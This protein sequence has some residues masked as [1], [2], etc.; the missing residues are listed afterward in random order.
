MSDRVQEPASELD[1]TPWG[2]R[3]GFR[4]TEFVVHED[5]SVELTGHRYLLSGYRMYQLIPYIEEVL[6]IRLDPRDVNQEIENKYVAPPVRNEAFIEAAE[7]AF[8]PGQIS[9]EDH[10]RLL[11]SHGQT[12]TDE[13]YRVLYGRL[14]RYADLVV[15]P[16]SEEDARQLVELAVR[17]D[18]CLV[19]YGGG[20]SVSSALALPPT[21]TRMIVSVDMHRMNRIE[22]ID[23]ENMRAC[24]QAGIVG[25]DLEEQLRRQDLTS[26]HEPDSIELSTLGGWIATNASGMKKNRYGNIERLV[27][28]VTLVSPSGVVEHLDSL[29]RVSM[30]MQ[31]QLLAFG[32]EGNLGL[33]TKAVI[34]IF[35]RPEETRYGSLVFPNFKLGVEFL[36]ELSETDYIPASIRLV[37]NIQFKF[38]MALKGQS[39]GIAVLKEKLA[40][41]YVTRIRGFDPDEMVAATIVMEGSRAEVEYQRSNL[42]RLAARYHGVP[43]GAD[44]GRRGYMLTYAIAYIRDFVARY[45]VIGETF[46]TSVPWSKI[47]RVC[48]AVE[49]KAAE[50]QAIWRLPGKFYVSYRV[51]QVYH[52][53]VCIY[54]M[55]GLYTKGVPEPEVVFGKIEKSLRQTI[56]DSGGSISHHHGVGKLRKEFVS[57]TM[58]PAAIDLLKGV[59]QSAD[60]QNVFGIRNNV[61]AD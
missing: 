19:P 14:E 59:K 21:E 40:K 9:W 55:Y 27:E 6:D 5:G 32:S 36:R 45:H 48:Q 15:Y 22:W 24:V 12:T 17:H 16:E 28:Q 3:W 26:G 56:L 8:Q 10:D 11:H 33:I 20:T 60:P 29:P 53:G 58:S 18:V 57:Q 7:Q 61:F 41:L 52:T 50:Q 23:R 4:D 47:H 49:Q 46:E 2:H 37:D 35:P 30:G 34:K 43:A 51:T 38:G 44:A 54:F 31:P 13:V 39:S 25:M 1:P 42:N